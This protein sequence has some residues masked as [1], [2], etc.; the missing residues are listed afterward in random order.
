MSG[1]DGIEAPFGTWGHSNNRKLGQAVCN[2][3]QLTANW[4]V[5]NGATK[6]AATVGTMLKFLLRLKLLNTERKVK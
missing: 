3:Q 6:H 1:I 2:K 4:V 5:G